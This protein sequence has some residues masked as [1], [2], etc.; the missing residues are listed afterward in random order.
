[1]TA[2]GDPTTGEIVTFSGRIMRPLAPSPDDL[3]I[4]DIAHALANSCRFT[5]HVRRFYSVAQHAVLVSE[6][7]P[8]ALRLCGLMHDASEA[9]LSDISRP[10]KR[11][12][13]FGEVYKAAEERL[14]LVIA[15]RFGFEWPPDEL[16]HWADDVLLRSEQRDL[17]PN[18][19]RVAGDD[20]LDFPI[21]P[22]LPPLAERAFL[23]RY[24][25]LTEG[26]S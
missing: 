12:P 7:L 1:M 6:I 24:Y 15:E 25:E 21:V 11:Q 3:C 16:I 14:M 22:L 19:L 2:V 17:M 4:E 23:N 13:V 20:Y 5:G 8:P 18:L 10:V 26:A 9:Y